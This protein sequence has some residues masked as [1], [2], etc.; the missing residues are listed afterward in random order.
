MQKPSTPRG[1]ART[2]ASP[3][4]PGGAKAARELER[5]LREVLEDRLT[6]AA[7][8]C[9]SYDLPTRHALGHAGPAASSAVFDAP[10]VVPA[11]GAQV[12]ACARSCMHADWAPP[13][14]K[15]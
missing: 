14:G 2:P 8:E 7:A 4:T 5:R 13:A 11:G 6:Y 15:L 1:S 9:E 10:S 12:R 3:R